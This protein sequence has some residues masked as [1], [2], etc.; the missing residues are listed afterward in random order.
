[1]CMVRMWNFSMDESVMC[2]QRG[3][4][5]NSSGRRQRTE[6][7]SSV[8]TIPENGCYECRNCERWAETC[9][10]ARLYQLLSFNLNF[11]T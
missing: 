5:R 2:R 7:A 8:V 4:F 9:C 11:R 1:M 6:S 3:S 10:S